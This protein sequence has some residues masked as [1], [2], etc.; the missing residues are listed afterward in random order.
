[1]SHYRMAE[2][3]EIEVEWQVL[4]AGTKVKVQGSH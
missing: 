2:E 4:V 3:A 1:M